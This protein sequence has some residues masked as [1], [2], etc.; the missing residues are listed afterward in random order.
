MAGITGVPLGGQGTFVETPLPTG[1]SLPAGVIPVWTCPDNLVTL[2]PS[3]DG[4]SCVALV[5]A[6][7]TNTNFALTVSATLPDGT[8]PA[9]TVNVPIL[10][11]EVD[12]FTI[13]QTA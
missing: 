10:P 5:D 11:G 6:S 1:D 7:D 3:S 2:T 13:N 4:T 8:K 9:S 12:G